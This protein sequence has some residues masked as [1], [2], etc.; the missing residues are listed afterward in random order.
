MHTQAKLCNK[1]RSLPQPINNRF[2]PQPSRVYKM[3]QKSG[4][5]TA[6]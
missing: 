6:G 3:G 4:K 5:G 2:S 1:Q